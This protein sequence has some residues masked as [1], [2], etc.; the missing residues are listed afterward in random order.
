MIYNT[1]ETSEGLRER[2]NAPGS[3]LYK[4]QRRMLDML[5]YIDGVCK[6]LKIQYRLDGGTCL[7]AVRHKGFIPWDDDLDIVLPRKDWKKIVSYLITHP[8]NQ[9]K[10]QCHDTDPGYMGAWAVLRDTKSEYIIDSK[11][12]NARKYR[13]LQVDLFPY[14]FGNIILL[15]NISQHLSFF[16]IRKPIEKGHLKTA[17]FFYMFLN[18]FLFPFFR[19]FNIFGDHNYSSHSYGTV[20]TNRDKH[21]MRIDEVIPYKLIEFEGYFFPGPAKPERILERIYGNYMDLPSEGNRDKHKA[22][23]KIWD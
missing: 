1:G 2:Y 17:V 18:N 10:I 20:W 15:Q 22:D 3:K 16:L 8:H 9:Y 12:H 14:D 13:G 5:L 11:I 23:Y 4:A 21:Y 19:L 6:E 7:G